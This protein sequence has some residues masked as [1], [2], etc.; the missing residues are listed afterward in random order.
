MG[1]KT[2]VVQKRSSEVWNILS[3]VKAEF[4]KFGTQLSKVDKQLQTASKSL[5][6]LRHTRTRAMDRKMQNI[7]VLDN[8]KE[9]NILEIP[10]APEEENEE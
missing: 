4:S 10:D 7:E 6:D 2:L 3:A 1:F 9:E 5:G 8:P